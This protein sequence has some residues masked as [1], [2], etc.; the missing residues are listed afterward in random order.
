VVKL[1]LIRYG[2]ESIHQ[3]FGK[4]LY[5]EDTVWSMRREADLRAKHLDAAGLYPKITG[6][7]VFTVWSSISHRKGTRVGK[8]NEKRLNRKKE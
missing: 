1:V 7:K 6:E 8:A 2:K 4:Q 5:R 3:F